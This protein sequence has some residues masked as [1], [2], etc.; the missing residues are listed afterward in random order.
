MADI[1]VTEG[2]MLIV[3]HETTNVGTINGEQDIDLVADSTTED[4]QDNLDLDS[5]ETGSGELYWLT[6]AGDAG[7]YTVTAE[8]EDTT[9][10]SIEVEVIS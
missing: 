2:D 7:T 3:T 5:G 10:D 9:S 6:E 1:T 4:T 8:S